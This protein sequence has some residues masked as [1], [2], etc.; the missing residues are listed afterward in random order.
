MY[1]I[2]ALSIQLLRRIGTVCA[3]KLVRTPRK[4]RNT[5]VRKRE[6]STKGHMLHEL[7]EGYWEVYKEGNEIWLKM[8]T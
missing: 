4:E 7:K 1:A 3:E 2:V 5:G 8:K 6:K